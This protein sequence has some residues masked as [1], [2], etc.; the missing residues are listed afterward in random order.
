[1]PGK[2]RTPRLLITSGAPAFGG[3]F[4]FV[5]LTVLACGDKERSEGSAGLNRLQHSASPYL[6]QHADNPVDWYEWGNEA[7][8]KAK[9]ENKPILIS[10]G[11]AACHWC[12]VMEEE[13]FMDTAVARYMNE[14]FVSIKIDREERPDIDQ[15]Y[16]DAA[17]LISGNSGWPLNAFALPDGRPFYAATYFP[18]ENW[19]RLIQQV[20]HAYKNDH[21]NVIKQAV[22]LTKGIKSNHAITFGDTSYVRNENSFKELFSNWKS[23]FDAEKGGLTGSP[24]FPLPVVWEFLLQYHY[25]TGEQHALELVMTTLD[26]ILNGGLFDDLEGG[27]SRYAVDEDWVV[28]HFEKM[29]YDNGQLVS[30]F[31]HAYQV[32][33]KVSYKNAVE[34]TLK[35]V[36]GSLLS[37][38]GGFYSSLN[39]DSEGEEGK[40]YVWRKSEIEDVLDDVSAPVFIAYYNI[41][42]SGNWEHGK[43]ILY[44]K[45]SPD[46]FAAKRRMS[47]SDFN[48]QISNAKNTLLE[49]RRQRISPSLDNK[50]LV[51]WNALMLQGYV[52]AYFAFG[53]PEYLETALRSGNFISKN[54]MQPKGRL[55][56]SFKDGRAGIDAFLE[57]YALLSRAFIQLYQATF[58][59]LWLERAKELTEYTLANFSDKETDLFYYASIEADDLIMRRLETADNVMPSSNAVMAEVLFMLAEFYGNK[60]YHLRSEVMLDRIVPSFTTNGPYYARWASVMGMMTYKPYEVAVVGPDALEKSKMIQRLYLPTAIFMGG[61]EEN[62]P[63]LQNKSVPNRTII[64]VCRNR[65]CKSPEEVPEN[66]IRQMRA[67]HK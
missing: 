43:N 42:D 59:I 53:K 45:V 55:L 46:D 3:I 28:P 44:S 20:S 14:N 64:Y 19:L 61:P 40:Y 62:L 21:D 1:M 36:E 60:E 26:G 47:L 48:S 23:N 33:N 10:I 67:M 41:S 29:L 25:L 38:E 13:T 18:R 24:K 54:F 37:P 32:T 56:R 11:Y 52:D 16:L 50:I 8:Q 15:I 5:A 27:F 58:D 49:K 12:H 9:D 31:S 35:F 51:S 63:L 66:A 22:A 7:L 17:Q 2:A 39:A 30:L 65:I 57:D 34:K 6:Q 4:F